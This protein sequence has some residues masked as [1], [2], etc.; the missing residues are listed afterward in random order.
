[1]D[2]APQV[3][4]I[5]TPISSDKIQPVFNKL[6]QRL[7]FW[8]ALNKNQKISLV[9]LVIILLVA[10]L[11]VYIALNPKNFLFP[12]ASQLATPPVTPPITPPGPT[13]TSSHRPTP[14]PTPSTPGPSVV[15]SPTPPPLMVNAP[16]PE[17]VRSVLVS[18]SLTM[19]NDDPSTL[20]E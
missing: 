13:P 4:V 20:I 2:I 1:M 8:R 6:K 18:V 10:P 7:S 5:E 19:V 11:G 14:T 12:W 15:P 3:P 9:S 17:M 16:V